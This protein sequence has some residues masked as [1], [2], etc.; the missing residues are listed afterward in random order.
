M[1]NVIKDLERATTE[2][3][4]EF[5]ENFIDVKNDIDFHVKTLEE[6]IKNVDE[7]LDSNG[8]ELS[9][10]CDILQEL[11]EVDDAYTLKDKFDL[12]RLK[13]IANKRYGDLLDEAVEVQAIK[14]RLEKL[15]NRIMIIKCWR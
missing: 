1:K 10:W 9:K 7:A 8:E 2:Y 11:Y 3:E 6:T 15:L 4:R 5:Q 13:L 14:E 12:W